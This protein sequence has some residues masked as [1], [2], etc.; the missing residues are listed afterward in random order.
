MADV[1]LQK[2]ELIEQLAQVAQDQNTT[3]EALLNTAVSNFL[4]QIA[5]QK[6]QSE[7]EAFKRLHPQLVRKYLGNYVAIHNGDVVDQDSNLRKLH[8]RIR[9]HYGR[10]PILLRQVTQDVKPQDLV[11]R[12]P[13]LDHLPE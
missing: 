10:L 4:D 5:S 11:F 12:S 3:P 2:P 9:K 6:I 7:I 8:L 1:T 13:K